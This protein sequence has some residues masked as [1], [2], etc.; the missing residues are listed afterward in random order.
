[1]VR[2]DPYRYFR[3]EAR[4]LVD[5]MVQ[6]VLDLERD[7]TAADQVARLLRLAHTLKGAARVVKHRGIADRAHAFEEVLE[8][9][10]EA[11][12]GVPAEALAAVLGLL[13]EMGVELAAIEEVPEPAADV[14]DAPA[15]P[16]GRAR[17][18]T[19]RVE[20]AVMDVVLTGIVEAG[21]RLGA[22]QSDRV[23]LAR[24]TDLA[25]LLVEQLG[26]AERGRAVAEELRSL[27]AA[28]GRQLDEAARRVDQELR[29]ARQA[30]ERLRLVPADGGFTA[31]ARAARDVAQ[32][33]GKQVAFTGLGHD[34]RLDADVLETIDVALLQVVRNAVAHGIEPVDERRAA[35]KPAE[36]DVTLEVTRRGHRV[37]FACRDDGRGIDLAA[38]RAAAQARGLAAADIESLGSDALFELLLQGG[39]S[40][41]DTVSEVSGRGIG[42]DVVRDAAQ[43]LGGTV[44][45]ATEAG[46]GTT[47]ELEVPLSLTTV[48]TL[49]LD[50]GGTT[51]SVPLH[52]VEAT[53]RVPPQHVVWSTSGATVLQ[54][55]TAIPFLP[56]SDVLARRPGTSA[57]SVPWSVI[58]LRT[59]GG[60]VALGVD[61]LLG[62]ANVIV[63]PLPPLT[64]AAPLVSGVTTDVDGN[65]Q[66]VLDPDGL[67]VEA[68]RG[69]DPPPAPPRPPEILVVDDSLTTRMLEHSILDA[70][71][72]EVGLASSAEEA[73]T[74]LAERSYD[75]V[76]VDIEM[77]GIDGFTFVERLRADPDLARLP[78]ILVTSLSSAEDQE[79]GRRVGADGYVVKGDFDQDRLLRQIRSLLAG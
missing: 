4:E 39:I 8:P 35:G 68:R 55:G 23:G 7:A 29:L 62:T 5:Q 14:T 11:S 63:R 12:A 21:N 27:L 57:R 30:A 75:L 45:V 47:I 56:L 38:V 15:E 24:A 26:P 34:V 53:S 6:G 50:A 78:A 67:G 74:I 59:A 1:M 31:L 9:H 25:A 44:H 33:H 69:V 40:T 71:G 37:C 58:V 65:Q 64:P 54:D 28:T 42:L 22:V 73:L 17:A 19:A 20:V 13:D 16:P 48:T 61:R 3:I 51:A 2:R 46:R 36:G 10:R 66:L 60:R 18:S 43:R 76:L 79:R 70:A 52:A 49:A 32:E 77:P 41:A 72:F